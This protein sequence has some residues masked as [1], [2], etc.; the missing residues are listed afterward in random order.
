MANNTISPRPNSGQLIPRATLVRLLGAALQTGSTR[1]ARQASLSWLAYFPGDLPIKLLYG[2]AELES[3]NYPRA[4]RVISDL[5]QQDPE[6]LEAW[7]Y[8][9][10]AL[11]GSS[12]P[13][14]DVSSFAFELAD[15]RA[16]AHA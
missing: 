10:Q 15:C 9:A 6:Y 13:D 16:T 4:S 3:G 7:V 12:I 11:Q 5:C 2:R 8:L 1:F 14:E